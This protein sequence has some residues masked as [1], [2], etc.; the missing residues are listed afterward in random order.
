MGRG[1]SGS[2]KRGA[3]GLPIADHN[4]LDLHLQASSEMQYGVH[5]GSSFSCEVLTGAKK[6]PAS[7]RCFP[8]LRFL[9]SAGHVQ[10]E[11][12]QGAALGELGSWTAAVTESTEQQPVTLLPGTTPASKICRMC[13]LEKPASEFKRARSHDGLMHIC[14]LCM[15]ASS[16]PVMH[17]Y[18]QLQDLC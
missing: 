3:S 5:M 7:S 13:T 16:S 11:L 15:Q 1:R 17:A 14:T 10:M 6:P 8:S 12:P 18:L 4:M 9:H 2:V